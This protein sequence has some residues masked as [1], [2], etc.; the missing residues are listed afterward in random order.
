MSMKSIA[1]VVMAGCV[2]VVISAAPGF[3]AQ[4]PQEHQHAATDQAKPA[5]GMAAKDHAMMAEREKMMADMKAADQRLTDLVTRMN[6]ASGAEQTTAIAAAV[7]EMVAQSRSMREGMMK[8]QQGMMPHMME[9]MQE[10]KDSMAMCPMMK[11]MGTM[12]P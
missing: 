1:T 5:S 3:A 11:Q 9:H 2:A 12:K 4:T 8:M 6:S 10:G 7:T